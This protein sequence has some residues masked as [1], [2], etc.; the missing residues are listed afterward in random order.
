MTT[1]T[2]EFPAA[3][4][5]LRDRVRNFFY[6]EE[7]PYG[8]A[9]VRIAMS[10]TLLMP[11]LPRWFYT[12]E[13][14]STDGSPS[15]IWESFGYYEFLPLFSGGVIVA[16]HSTLIFTLITSALGW[17][18][19]ISLIVATILYTY[20]TAADSVSTITKYTVIA[21]HVLFLL[22][23]SPCGLVWSLDAYLKQGKA[24]FLR[25]T[26]P[27]WPQRLLQ[28][29]IGL[30]YFGA[31]ITKLHTPSYFSGDQLIF[32]M[33]TNLMFDNPLGRQLTSFPMMLVVFAYITIVWEIL[34]VFTAWKGYPRL[35]MLGI[36]ATFHLMTFFTL[37]LTV[38]PLICVSTYFAFLNERDV[39]AIQEFV[40]RWRIARVNWPKLPLRLPETVRLPS[41]VVYSIVAVLAIAGGVQAEHWLDPYGIRR[42][43]GRYA[44]REMDDET[45]RTMLRSEEPIREFDKFFSFDL[46]TLNIGGFLVDR[47]REFHHGERVLAEISLN[48]PH[49]DMWVECN[50]H[51]GEG[52]IMNRIGQ[53][54]L[55][56]SLRAEFFYDMTDSMAPGEY[57]L[58]LTSGGK[59]V[60]R[61]RFELVAGG[62]APVAN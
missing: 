44:L 41:A 58:V 7:A 57:Q 49:E 46:G 39:K 60:D 23:L 50:L 19:R 54:V 47:R 62:A 48:T 2:G 22:S 52:R 56:E 37:G 16:L 15:P 8:L 42:P 40:S 45:A 27:V 30:V 36:G 35:I 21:S 20:L 38:F 14:Y 5:G 43:E 29:L 4:G 33:L 28:L 12:R 24:E 34:F 18:T 61:R 59:E 10:L 9:L 31:A 6:A 25:R 1:A 11:M 26:A 13:L 17:C 53:V 55:R 3:T 51:D 32:W